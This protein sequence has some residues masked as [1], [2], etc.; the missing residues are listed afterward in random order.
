MPASP[1][2]R[3]V[4]VEVHLHP[5][6]DPPFHLASPHLPTNSD[7]EFEFKNQGHPGFNINFVLQEP[8]HGYLWPE[9]K[10]KKQAVWSEAGGG[11]C[12]DSEIWDIFRAIRITPDRKTLVVHN[13]NTQQTELGKFGY[14]LRVVK[15]PSDWLELDPGGDNQNGPIGRFDWSY[16]MVGIGSAVMTTATIALAVS[17]SGHQLFCPAGS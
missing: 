6:R 15:D 11:A 17:L 8:T 2:P 5:D 7:G 4:L 12:P 16:A 3:D 9:N 10:H 14:T 13:G 1:L